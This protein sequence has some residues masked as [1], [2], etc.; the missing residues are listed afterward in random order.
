MATTDKTVA[1]LKEVEPVPESLVA[2][3][4]KR[5]DDGRHHRRAKLICA[6]FGEIRDVAA[7]V[8]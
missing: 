7:S 4:S 8:L 3:K 1:L 5:H 6:R 2:D